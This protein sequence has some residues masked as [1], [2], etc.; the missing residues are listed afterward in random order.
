MIKTFPPYTG[1]NRQTVCTSQAAAK[2]WVDPPILQRVCPERREIRTVIKEQPMVRV[3]HGTADRI[4]AWRVRDAL[5]CHPLLGGATAQISIHA[6]FES[7]TL[8]GW[9]L[10]DRVQQLAIRLA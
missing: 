6:D 3:S 2:R 8:E 10:D 7:V 9:T 4:T 5:A 1:T